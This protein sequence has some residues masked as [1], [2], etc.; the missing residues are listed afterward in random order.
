[1]SNKNSAFSSLLI[2][3]MLLFSCKEPLL[4][5]P[6]GMLSLEYE[7]PEYTTHDSDCPYLFEGNK[8]AQI[9]KA[10]RGNSCD[11]NI[12]YPNLNATIY[13]SY[14]KV[15]KDLKRLLRDAQNLTQEHAIKAD[16]IEVIQY[17]NKDQKAYGAFYEITGNAASQSQFYITDSVQHFVMG[18]IYFKAKPNYDSIFPATIYLRDDMRRIMESIRWSE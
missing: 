14:R 16:A 7:T 17:G 4:P 6:K 5:K 9:Q 13:L 12:E 18:S 11:L 3:C 10:K 8:S 2:I 15:N 1:M